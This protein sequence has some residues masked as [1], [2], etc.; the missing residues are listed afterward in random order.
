MAHRNTLIVLA[1][2]ASLA[3]CSAEPI[4]ET[5]AAARTGLPGDTQLTGQR[6][7]AVGNATNPALLTLPYNGGEVMG[8]QSPVT[9]YLL[10]YGAW[11]DVQSHYFINLS[12]HLGESSWY[13]ILSDYRDNT[14]ASVHGLVYGGA[15]YDSYSQGKKIGNIEAV[16]GHA[17]NDPHHPLPRNGKGVYMILLSPD[18]APYGPSCGYHWASLIGAQKY[19]VL[20][21]HVA[22][23]P[24]C[25]AGWLTIGPTGT[26]LDGMASIFVHE[27]AETITDPDG[28]RHSGYSTNAPQAG[29]PARMEIGDLCAWNL[30]A[31]VFTTPNDRSANLKVGDQYY[32]VQE[33]LTNSYYEG[34]C[35]MGAPYT[36][37][38]D[39]VAPQ[40]AT[41]GDNCSRAFVDLTSS[42]YC[43]GQSSC[44]VQLT[45]QAMAGYVPVP[46]C[47][48]QLT[49]QWACWS[50]PKITTITG[51]VPGQT[52]SFGCP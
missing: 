39:V 51:P 38:G 21:A 44:S 48:P 30:G 15:Y 27:L 43:Y 42:I 13:G 28:L 32:L 18:V 26:F 9:V 40:S 34:Y 8:T 24:G 5:S 3:A 36:A 50:G 17:L 46:G 19:S 47:T 33:I 7:K 45:S 2:T 12:Q 4:S 10:F 1:V 6:E 37:A 52:L 11:T 41:Y 25:G 35:S 22:Q 14:G 20:S 29:F 31:G 49:V 16:L 23:Q